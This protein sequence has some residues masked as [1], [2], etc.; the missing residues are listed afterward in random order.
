[1]H[2]VRC[3]AT[4]LFLSASAACS[5]ARPPV[6]VATSAS[7]WRAVATETD[8]KRLRDWREEWLPHAVVPTLTVDGV[9][10]L[11]GVAA[12]R[13]LGDAARLRGLDAGDP[14][15]PRR[16]PGHVRPADLSW[17]SRLGE[18]FHPEQQRRAARLPWE[19]EPDGA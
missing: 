11:T 17:V 7:E 14:V 8:R 6:V 16:A 13:W 9:G 19:H 3:A 2:P 4:L 10:T 15:A 1:M 18:P 12:V 5:V